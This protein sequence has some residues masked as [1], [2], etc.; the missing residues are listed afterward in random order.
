MVYF[1][2]YTLLIK[3]D[4][5]LLLLLMSRDRFHDDDYCSFFSRRYKLEA[6]LASM[7]WKI[8]WEDICTDDG[9]EAERSDAVDSNSVWKKANLMIINHE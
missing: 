5:F 6:E 2:L 7:S 9:R 8:K 1:F 4:H 3:D